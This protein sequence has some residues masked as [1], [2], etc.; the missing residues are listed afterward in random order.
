MSQTVDAGAIVAEVGEIHHSLVTSISPMMI[1]LAHEQKRVGTK[2]AALKILDRELVKLGKMI[3]YMATKPSARGLQTIIQKARDAQTQLDRVDDDEND[4]SSES[5]FEDEDHYIDEC[6]SDDVN[7]WQLSSL[8]KS[9]DPLDR[10]ILANSIIRQ[11]L[12]EIPK[13]VLTEKK[14]HNH[15]VKDLSGVPKKLLKRLLEH[16]ANHHNIKSTFRSQK[17]KRKS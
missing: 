14:C 13:N 3:R 12:D 17:R 8:E 15:F 5:E 10:Q 16:A 6:L 1:E 2:L 9:S 11:K 4:E 7:P